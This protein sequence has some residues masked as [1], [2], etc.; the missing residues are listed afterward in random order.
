MENP[1]Y[2]WM[3]WGYR[4]F[5]KPL[6]GTWPSLDNYLKTRLTL[7]MVNI[8]V[9]SAAKQTPTITELTFTKLDSKTWFCPKIGYPKDM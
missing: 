3:I 7:W 4:Y 5:R 6:Y 2:K 1:I 8:S 9:A